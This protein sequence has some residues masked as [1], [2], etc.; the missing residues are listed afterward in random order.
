MPSSA[1][2]AQG[3]TL[4]RISEASRDPATVKTALDLLRDDQTSLT[5][6]AESLFV[7]RTDDESAHLEEH[8]FGAASWWESEPDVEEILRKGLL[9]ALTLAAD[10]NKPIEA[11]WIC[12]GADSR[13]EVASCLNPFQVTM[14]ILTPRVPERAHELWRTLSLTQDE[15]IL[16]VRRG[17]LEQDAYGQ[18]VVRQD[19]DVLTLRVMTRQSGE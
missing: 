14:L 5:E 19:G 13:F 2:V 9:E 3:P 15:P 11:Y 7:V 8:W 12:A 18:E 16:I 17:P 10:N 1:N 4:R 6:I